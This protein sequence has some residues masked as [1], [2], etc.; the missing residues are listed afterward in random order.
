MSIEITYRG[1]ATFARVCPECGRFV[2][3]NKRVLMN[4]NGPVGANA[5]CKKHGRIAMP[6][7][8][9]Y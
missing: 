1:G 3:P 8:G 2:K 6:F 4:G 5:R 9:Y 7:T